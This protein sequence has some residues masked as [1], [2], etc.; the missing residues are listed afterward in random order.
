MHNDAALATR[1]I[2]AGASGFLLK[3][4]AGEELCHRH[5]PGVAGPRAPHPRHDQG[6][7]GA[8][9]QRT[10]GES[11]NRRLTARQRDVLRAGIVEGQRM[12]EDRGGGLELS[13]RTVEAHKSEMMEALDVQSTPNWC[14]TRCRI[15][16]SS[17]DRQ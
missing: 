5:R 15:R 7:H 12:K 14:A 3:H 9:G 16:A 17:T 1:A 8:D 4:S 13:P 10:A 2:R 6:R 11:A